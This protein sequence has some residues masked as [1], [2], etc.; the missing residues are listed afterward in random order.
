MPMKIITKACLK[1]EFLLGVILGCMLV[2]AAVFIVG[3]HVTPATA[4]PT[5]AFNVSGNQYLPKGRNFRVGYV[6]GALDA[7][8]LARHFAGTGDQVH[9]FTP[10]TGDWTRHQ[11]IGIVDRYMRDHPNQGSASAALLSHKALK[12]ACASHTPPAD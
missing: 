3:T 2:L 10:C 12:A 6:A 5:L 4:N 11:L 9:D 8:L 7:F 1:A